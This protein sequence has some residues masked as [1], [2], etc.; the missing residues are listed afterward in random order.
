MKVGDKV[1]YISD[2]DF[3]GTI[4]QTAQTL[5][6]VIWYKSETIEWVPLYSLKVIEE[7]KE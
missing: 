3:I 7:Y 2:P 5:C 6:R 4:L 1:V